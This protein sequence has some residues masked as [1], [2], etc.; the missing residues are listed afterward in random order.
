MSDTIQGRMDLPGDAMKAEAN[1]SS[2]SESATDASPQRRKIRG[3]SWFLA[4][5][6]VLSSMLMYALDTTITADLGPSIVTQFDSIE[7]L[8]WLSV[9]F[10][11]GG[12]VVV[13]PLG[14]LYGKFNAK[15][16]YITSLVI[17][18]AASAICGA[19]PNM[20]AMIV[21]RVFLGAAGSGM[22]F[23]VLNLLS[24]Y[25]EDKERPIY[26][27]LVGFIWGIG[28]VL[29]PVVG[30][31]F[32]KISWRWAFYL[33][34]FIGGFF[35]PIYV[36]LLPPSDPQPGATVKAR[37]S[38]FDGLGSLLSTACLLCGIMAIN[39]GGALY[40]W[41][42]GSIIALFVV[43]GV[44]LVLFSV[45]QVFSWTTSETE[46][47]FPVQFL[48]SK[49]ACLLFVC[50]ACSN[51]AG[52]IPIFYIP[53]YFIFSRGDNALDAA[54]RLL[55]L[56]TVMSA[57]IIANGFL[58]SRWGYYMPWYVVGAACALVGNVLLSLIT[59]NTAV[60]NIYGYEVLVAVGAGLFIQAGYAA[61]QT[62][63]DAAEMAYAIA[64]MMLA[65]FIG[66]VFGLAVAGAVFVN[67]AISSLHRILPETPRAEIQ[68]II[69][70]TSSGAL[71]EMSAEMRS[72]V[73]STIV[74]S[75]Q[76][77]FIA[78]Y[79]AAAVALVASVFLKR[80][81]ALA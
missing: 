2:G 64:F 57:S 39:F 51:A 54:V 79:A 18:L 4:V 28:T 60:A 45:Q 50:A 67:V 22:Y 6:A 17:F 3:F 36:F 34:L 14:K 81:R 43:A 47:M 11:L 27:S 26:L 46:R 19:A 69:G 41:G 55:P 44:L 16:L 33:N 72:Q 56:I 13:L 70:G 10:M 73:I 31:G 80:S 32:D 49:E 61:I 78:A 21:G 7:L 12:I 37:L 62:V 71:S 66:I 25:T 68:S 30:G 76:G 63:V 38:N 9:G 65:Q 20:D 48:R 77:V 5:V 35:A 23:G 29:G 15:W 24:V 53:V 1:S 59:A 74:D 42:S 75:L 8:P 40:A 52:F 58:M